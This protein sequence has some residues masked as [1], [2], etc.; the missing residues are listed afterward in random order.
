MMQK[1]EVYSLEGSLASCQIVATFDRSSYSPRVHLCQP[2]CGSKFEVSPGLFIDAGALSSLVSVMKKVNEVNSQFQRQRNPDLVF[3]ALYSDAV[4]S[5]DE[6][7]GIDS[8]G[9]VRV[10]LENPDGEDYRYY[11]IEVL[12]A[13]SYNSIRTLRILNS[14]KPNPKGK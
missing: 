5:V 13:L 4:Y 6:E 1:T 8:D 7:Y 11:P 14:L 9:E 10:S 12:Q 3:K 2:S